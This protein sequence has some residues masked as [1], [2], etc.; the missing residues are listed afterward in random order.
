[1]QVIHQNTHNHRF[2]VTEDSDV[3]LW[4]PWSITNHIRNQQINICVW[5]LSINQNLYFTKKTWVITS[6][7]S[8]DE[9][10]TWYR[11]NL[12]CELYSSSFGTHLFS[13]DFQRFLDQADIFGHPTVQH[14]FR[15]VL[16]N[17]KTFQQ[18]LTIHSFLL[19]MLVWALIEYWQIHEVQLVAFQLLKSR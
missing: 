14:E 16:E 13:V 10:L 4:R 1:M 6:D 3:I 9:S 15:I 19:L 18:I 12:R 17:S 11:C 2:V 7:H 8:S 5:L